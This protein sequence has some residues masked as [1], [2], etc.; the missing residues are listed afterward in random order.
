MNRNLLANSN[1]SS[2][3]RPTPVPSPHLR[4]TASAPIPTLHSGCHRA[5]T[6]PGP[7]YRRAKSPCECQKHRNSQCHG[8]CTDQEVRAVRIRNVSR[9]PIK[10]RLHNQNQC[11]TQVKLRDTISCCICE[12]VFHTGRP[13]PRCLLRAPTAQC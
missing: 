13:R 3:L 9:R 5:D 8:Q 2:C 6:Q 4:Q 10:I 11:G 1:A 12:I 7:T